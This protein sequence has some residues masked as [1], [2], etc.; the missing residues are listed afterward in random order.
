MESR[1][2]KRLW[3]LSKY[4]GMIWILTLFTTIVINL[5]IGL[6]T[7]LIASLI[8]ILTQSIKPYACLL[9]RVA[10]TDIFL[11]IS[12]FKDVSRYFIN[13]VNQ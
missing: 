1:H 12:R 2:F 9:G 5:D 4:D 8:N 3:D 11:D 6:F 7:G 13:F 10:E